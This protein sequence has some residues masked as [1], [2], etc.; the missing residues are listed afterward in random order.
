MI[1]KTSLLLVLS[2]IVVQLLSGQTKSTGKLSHEFNRAV[3]LSENG[4]FKQ[5]I[6]LF[7]DI[8]KQDSENIPVL[9]YLGNCYLNISN[10]P[11]SAIIY[12]EKA[13]HVLPNDERDTNLGIDLQLS[14]GKAYQRLLHQKEAIDLYEKLI[15]ELPVEDEEIIKETRREIEIC[16]NALTL[17]SH[18]VEMKVKNLGPLVN[19]EYD[20]HSPLV[21]AD[22]SL[23]LFTS[24]RSSNNSEQLPDGQY[25]ERTYT[26]NL[27]NRAWNKSRILKEQHFK[28]PGHEAG[29]CLSAD[30]QELYIYRRNID[31]ANLYVSN[32]DGTTWTEPLKLPA[33]I[34]S[35][36]DETHA[37]ISSDKNTLYFTSNRVGGVGGLDIYRVRKLPNGEWG[38]AQN[39]ADINTP[40]DEE[41]PVIHPDGKTL[42]FSSEGHNSMGQFDIFYSQ[43]KADSSWSAPVNIGYPINTPEDDLFFVPTTTQ[44]KAYYA[45][46]KFEDSHGGSDIFQIEYEEPEENKLVVVK[47]KV[48]TGPDTPLEEVR[49]YVDDQSTNKNIGIYR[50]HPGTGKYLLILEADKKYNIRFTGTGLEETIKP[51]TLSSAMTY[52]KQNQSLQ[53]EDVQ[54][55]K[56]VSI[57]DKKKEDLTQVTS[58]IP[59][60]TVQLL[61]LP[62]PVSSYKVFTNLE[63]HRIKEYACIDG[64]YRYTY[65]HYFGFK[66]S[67]KGKSIVLNTGNW[68]DAFI[69]EVRQF[70]TLMEE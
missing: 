26:S 11:D 68:Q 27:E 62:R 20:D 52:K 32:F 7:K 67:L 25:E 44:N 23:L 15:A 16:E 50:P 30:G 54:M 21:S 36:Y 35:R 48:N 24:R 37:S 47:G 2:C 61:T 46:S 1:R 64:L 38:L 14:L 53:I 5:A 45:S 8:L 22:E 3:K 58:N 57:V 51:L 43:M 31:G 19:S 28:T 18:P 70:D 65:G 60:Y 34:N 49:I 33:P 55:I 69:R 41:T 12:L 10:G 56:Q 42:Y 59:F 4:N 40:F 63:H 66:A 13:L 6:N 9:Y 29:V 17:I 39:L